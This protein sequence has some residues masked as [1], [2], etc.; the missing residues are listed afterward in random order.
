MTNQDRERDRPTAV[1]GGDGSLGGAAI[2]GPVTSPDAGV[3]RDPVGPEV[4]IPVTTDP[5]DEPA[6]TDPSVEPATAEREAADTAETP[7]SNRG[8]PAA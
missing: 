1:S 3:I 7:A 2:G 4:A 6:R 5:A 8:D